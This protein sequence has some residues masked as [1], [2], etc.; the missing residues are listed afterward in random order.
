[1]GD[2]LLVTGTRGDDRLFIAPLNDSQVRVR[3]GNRLLGDFATP[4]AVAIDALDGNDYVVVDPRL[5]GAVIAT[6]AELPDAGLA[7]DIIFAGDAAVIVDSPPAVELLG[8]VNQ[9]LSAHELALLQLLDQ[10][11]DDEAPAGGILKRRR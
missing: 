9:P 8:S 4:A 5:T 3:A 11:V 2:R 7:S 10:W 6:S 1:V